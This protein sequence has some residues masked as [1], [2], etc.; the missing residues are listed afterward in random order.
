MKR[1]NTPIL[2][3]LLAFIAGIICYDAYRAS[4]FWIVII[5]LL[6]I[7][8][9]FVLHRLAF[10]RPLNAIA[11]TTGISVVFIALGYLTSER[12]NTLNN[13]THFTHT[14]TSNPSTFLF[15]VDQVLKP[16][17]YQ[18]KYVVTLKTI[19]KKAASGKVILNVSKDSASQRLR[20]GTWYYTRSVLLPVPKPKNPFQFDYGS[21]LK[22]KQIY[23]QLSINKNELLIS[24]HTSSGLRVWASRFRESV[25][26]SIHSHSFTSDQLAVIDA[27]VLGQKNGIDKQISTNYASAGMMHILAVSGLHVGIILLLL[28][29]I[30]KPIAD[31]KLRWLR[32]II[33]IAMIWAFAFITGLS[34]SV[35]R[36]ATMFSFLEVGQQLG[37]KR[38]TTDAV[39]AS[40]VLLLLYD[41]FLIYQ[42]GFQL[43]YLAVIGILWIQ[44]WLSSFYTPGYYIDKLLWGIATV[45]V[46][47]QLGVLPLSLFYFHQFPGL[48]FLSNV[49][50]IPFLG[51]ILGGGILVAILAALDILPDA[52]VATYGYVIDLMNGFIFWVAS[53][54]AFITNHITISFAF[55][56]GLYLCIV[57]SIS[58]FKKFNNPRLVAASLSIILLTSIII[59]EKSN[60]PT[61]HLTIFNKSKSTMIGTFH[62]SKLKIHS[63]DSLHTIIQDSRV[64]NYKDGLRIDEV[65]VEGMQNY[66]RFKR[67][68]IL[69]IDSLGIYQLANA[70]PDY[71]LLTQSPKININ[72]L[73]ERFPKALIFADASNYKSYITRWKGT[74]INKKIP[75]HSTYEKGA[76]IIE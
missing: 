76:Y 41:P 48:F 62:N 33:I 19:N 73:T 13:D 74:C 24:Q 42:V 47:A 20:V 4:W 68:E 60:P 12:A 25:L 7:S 45:S 57:F 46:A 14:N 27:L 2:V 37:G 38:K 40:A 39:M 59:Y 54:E 22:R 70:N 28:R 44:P 16:T 65:A 10:K 35:L 63:T 55:L 58:L 23:G 18:D 36:A 9:L 49:I 52:L 61:T 53:K 21:Y 64:R 75:F 5:L 67:K 32:S 50:I 6:T 43:S 1:I 56:I 11:F 17:M 71:I 15:T 69:V 30:T 72:R 8:F 3:I 26:K 29:L 66:F 34:P 31:Y 51:I